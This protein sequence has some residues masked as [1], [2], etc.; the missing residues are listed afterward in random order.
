[1]HF[2][3][4]AGVFGYRPHYLT[5]AALLLLAVV[6]PLLAPGGPVSSVGPLGAGGVLW[7]NAAWALVSPQGLIT[8]SSEQRLAVGSPSVF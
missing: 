3:P 8:R 7:L 6:Y 2:L 5:E 4:L 1:M